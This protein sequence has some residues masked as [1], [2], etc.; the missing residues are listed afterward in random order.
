[1]LAGSTPRY[2]GPPPAQ[3]RNGPVRVVIASG[4]RRCGYPAETDGW[5]RPAP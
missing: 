5:A 3:G 4:T 2:E 1:M